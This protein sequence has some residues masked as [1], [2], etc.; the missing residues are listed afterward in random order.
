[1][2]ND[3]RFLVYYLV[4]FKGGLFLAVLY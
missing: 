1:V 2:G 4:I 3:G